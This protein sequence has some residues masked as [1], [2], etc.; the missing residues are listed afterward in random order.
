M[1][2]TKT[3]NNQDSQN[4]QKVKHWIRETAWEKSFHILKVQK[5]VI[6]DHYL[7]QL[8]GHFMTFHSKAKLPIN[9]DPPFADTTTLQGKLSTSFPS[10]FDELLAHSPKEHLWRPVVCVLILKKKEFSGI[11]IRAA[12]RLSSHCLCFVHRGIGMLGQQSIDT[13]LVVLYWLE[14]LYPVPLTRPFNGRK[15]PSLNPEKHPHT[16]IPPLNFKVCTM[17]S[18]R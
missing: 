12:C 10:M 3:S 9:L 1:T 14:C 15:G 8:P 18:N 2:E 13:N 5:S 11:E 7:Y 17:N 6:P 16:I 4:I